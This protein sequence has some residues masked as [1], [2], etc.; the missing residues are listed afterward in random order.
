MNLLLW[1]I[2]SATRTFMTTSANVA[3]LSNSFTVALSNKL[4]KIIWNIH[5]SQLRSVSA[6]PCEIWTFNCMWTTVN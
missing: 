2:K 4:Q 3:Q 6:P 5:T 1:S